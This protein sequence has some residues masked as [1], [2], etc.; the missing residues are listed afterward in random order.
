[1][2]EKIK[3]YKYRMVSKFPEHVRGNCYA[4]LDH[5]HTM[6]PDDVVRR[7]ELMESKI[8]ELEADRDRLRGALVQIYELPNQT[9]PEWDDEYIKTIEDMGA[10]AKNALK[11]VINE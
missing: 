5:G 2:S 9:C 10:M 7:L 1:M 6:F 3:R 8:K 4:I 11:G